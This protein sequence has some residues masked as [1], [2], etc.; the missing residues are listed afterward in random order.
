MGPNFSR[1]ENKWSWISSSESEVLG[2]PSAHISDAISFALLSII[3]SDPLL[4][5]GLSEIFLLH[6]M[7][8][9]KCCTSK[10]DTVPG[11][12]LASGPGRCQ[13]KGNYRVRVWLHQPL[14]LPHSWLVIHWLWDSKSTKGLKWWAALFN[15]VR[16]KKKIAIKARRNFPD[17]QKIPNIR[18]TERPNSQKNYLAW[19]PATIQKR[20]QC[21]SKY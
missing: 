16:L 15:K 4:K 13:S 19:E 17:F 8:S 21:T 3:M 11:A 18:T 5:I 12:M 2:E 1:N 20:K 7:W 9:V 6:G 14:P 10:Q